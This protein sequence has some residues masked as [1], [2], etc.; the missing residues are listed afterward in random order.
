MAISKSSNS[1]ISHLTREEAN[2][3]EVD[4][5]AFFTITDKNGYNYYRVDIPNTDISK[6][7]KIIEECE[8][9]EN[10]SWNAGQNFF[11][12][13]KKCNLLTYIV[14]NNKIIG[15]QLFSSCCFLNPPKKT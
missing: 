2:Q 1:T 15:F 6:L 13:F 3:Y 4:H 12:Y 5:E 7:T 9:I 8:Y 14:D 10:E 11:D